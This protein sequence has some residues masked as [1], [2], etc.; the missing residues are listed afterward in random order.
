[1]RRAASRDGTL[2]RTPDASPNATAGM[3]ATARAAAGETERMLGARILRRFDGSLDL[4]V[5]EMLAGDR[6][7][8]DAQLRA[9]LNAGRLHVEALDV[10]VP[11]DVTG[12]EIEMAVA[13]TIDRLEYGFL[14][15]R[16]RPDANLNGEVSLDVDLR[17]HTPSVDRFLEHATGHMDFAVWPR[18][19]AS[20]VL[21]R[22]SINAFLTLLPFLDRS[23]ESTVNCYFGR[24]DFTDGVVR[25]DAL[26]ID[27]TRVR[28]TGTGVVNLPKDAL[29]FRFS[30]RAKGVTFFSLQTPLRMEGSTSDFRVF[31]APGDWIEA[32]TRFFGSIVLVPLEILRNG[33]MPADGADVCANPTR[34]R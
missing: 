26:I 19:Q 22:W 29:S 25:E 30:P 13:A 12:R 3:L 15:R 2:D 8:A 32:L 34:R 24:L 23:G 28:A 4:A 11:G 21:D 27:T 10:R 31:A 1:M 33:P 5:K 20:G 7:L 14:A 18:D 6:R 9:T 17:A 16:W